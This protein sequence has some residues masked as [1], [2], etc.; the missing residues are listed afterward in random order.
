M[1]KMDMLENYLDGKLTADEMKAFEAIMSKDE[2]LYRE[3]KLHQDM[4]KALLNDKADDFRKLLDNAHQRYEKK[5]RRPLWYKMAA[6]VIVFLAVGGIVLLLTNR[7]SPTRDLADKYYQT[8]QPLNGVRSDNPDQDKILSAAFQAYDN[9]DFHSSARDFEALL[10][11]NP[12]NNQVRFYLAVTYMEDN[13]GTKAI[14]LLQEIIDSRDVY[15]LSQS[16]WYLGIC[17]LWLGRK[18]EA[19]LPFERLAKKKGYYQ[20]QAL[21]VLEEIKKMS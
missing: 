17:Y 13:K 1:E 8:Y 16:E 19:M 4:S 20:Q 15:Y 2:V 10:Q 9:G 12:A 7:S 6:A 18:D 5:D 14:R 21:K 11:L 3:Y